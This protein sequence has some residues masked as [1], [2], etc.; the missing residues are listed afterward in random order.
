[1]SCLECG[2]SFQFEKRSG[3]KKRRFCSHFCYGKNKTGKT[4]DQ[5]MGSE[6]SARLKVFLRGH[7]K[8]LGIRA[9]DP[10]RNLGSHAKVGATPWNKGTGKSKLGTLIRLSAKYLKWRREILERDHRSCQH[11]QTTQQLVVDHIKPLYEL[12]KQ[13]QIETLAQAEAIDELWNTENGRV[14]CDSCHKKTDTYG[15]R[16]VKGVMN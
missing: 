14:L 7:I 1:M 2:K 3:Y 6:K 4:Y 5:I 15:Y 13:H 16:V 12:M 9:A 8:R 10:V 11:C